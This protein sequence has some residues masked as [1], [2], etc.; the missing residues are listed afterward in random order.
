MIGWG[1]V[2]AVCTAGVATAVTAATDR[3]YLPVLPIINAAGLGYVVFFLLPVLATVGLGLWAGQRGRFAVVAAIVV[4]IV[5]VGL[6]W[7]GW[8]G[9]IVNEC[10]LHDNGCFD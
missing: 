6:S 8:I 9:L 3:L 7:A 2:L 10:V 4:A 5:V 1:V